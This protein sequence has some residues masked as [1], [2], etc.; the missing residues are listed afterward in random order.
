[1]SRSHARFDRSRSRSSRRHSRRR[2]SHS[3]SRTRSTRRHG[4][5]SSRR[6]SS[7]SL[8]RQRQRHA[9]ERRRKE[10]EKA[11]REDLTVLVVNLSLNVDER[12][13][14]EAFSE[15]AGKVRDVQCVKDARSGK[16]KGVAYVE[17]YTQDSVLKALAMSGFE[18]LGQRIRVQSSQAEKNRAAKAAK[19][20]EEAALDIG[21]STFTIFVGGLDG[22]LAAI[23]KNELKQLF[24]PFGTILDVE[25]CRNQVPGDQK[26]G[27]FLKFK[28]AS[29]AKEA[30]AAMHGF[31]IGGQQIRVSYASAVAAHGNAGKPSSV[32]LESLDDDQGLISGACTKIALMQ[33]LSRMS[34]Q[35][36]SQPSAPILPTGPST[37]LSVSNSS[38]TCQIILS[39]MFSPTDPGISQAGFFSEIR[40]DVASECSK[41]GKVE[42][43]FINERAIDGKVWLKFGSSLDAAVAF[44]A[45]NGRFFAGNAIQ[46]EYCSDAVWRAIVEE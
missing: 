16:S 28:R 31:E 7:E 38:P 12:D 10:M 27:A 42:R 30:M 26:G 18:L 24:S 21:E 9:E 20:L 15:H 29:E 1:M 39:N 36:N 11:Q 32:D 17:F 19:M 43:V 45:L 23:S 2:R 3:R 37:E 5:S 34:D 25:L 40:D 44:K 13:I 46:V 33:K 4:R 6:V 8:E 22:P 41:Y 14:Y 35:S